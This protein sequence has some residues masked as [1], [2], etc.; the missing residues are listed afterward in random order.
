MVTPQSLFGISY[1]LDEMHERG[2]TPDCCRNESVEGARE[3]R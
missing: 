1:L 2:R 3:D